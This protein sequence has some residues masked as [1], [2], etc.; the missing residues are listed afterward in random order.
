MRN[1]SDIFYL[2]LYI[3]ILHHFI[4]S[5]DLCFV[6]LDRTKSINNQC[7]IVYKKPR[8]Q[9]NKKPISPQ[10]ANNLFFFLI[11]ARLHMQT[12]RN[13][14]NSS[15]KVLHK[16]I[17]EQVSPVTFFFFHA[18]SFFCC[19]GSKSTHLSIVC[20]LLYLISSHNL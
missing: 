19:V 13:F 20:H 1:H 17:L 4:S 3:Y 5:F 12:S 2:F 7:F 8:H 10:K 15:V 11:F 18:L 14:S 6:L 16:G 9:A